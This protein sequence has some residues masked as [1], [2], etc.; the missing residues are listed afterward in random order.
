ML[1]YAHSL[2][3]NVIIVVPRLV[4]CKLIIFGFVKNSEKYLP[5]MPKI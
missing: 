1:G 2:K 5:T 4:W 3:I